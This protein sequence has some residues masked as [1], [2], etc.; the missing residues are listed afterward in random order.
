MLKKA[1]TRSMGQHRHIQ[2]R[3]IQ[4]LNPTLPP[5][6]S[7]WR[8]LDDEWFVSA[9][10]DQIL[11]LKNARGHCLELG[12]DNIREYRSNPGGSGYLVLNSQIY[13]DGARLHSEP[14]ERPFGPCLYRS[15]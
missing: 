10:A 14:L 1:L 4:K 15:L 7:G 12:F 11:T 5:Y 8:R 9:F 13:M 6:R 3:V 2:P